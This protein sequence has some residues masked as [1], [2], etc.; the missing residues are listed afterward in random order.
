MKHIKLDQ[1]IIREILGKDKF[2]MLNLDM[3]KK[4]GLTESLLLTYMLDK[5]DYFVSI[6]DK[7]IDT[8]M[9]FYR[10]DIEDKLGISAYH[11]RKAEKK[12]TTLEIIKVETIYEEKLTYN[13]YKLNLN[14]L[15]DVLYTPIK[16]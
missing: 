12:L 14:K 4:L 8:G 16:N 3:I 11:Q 1:R 13:L 15:V 2:L 10:I 9:I 5:F 7:I 6:N